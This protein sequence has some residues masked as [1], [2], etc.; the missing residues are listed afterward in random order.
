MAI[1]I[2]A[3]ILQSGAV[4]TFL[5]NERETQILGG[6]QAHYMVGDNLAKG[7]R[8]HA[9][10]LGVLW[11]VR[12]ETDLHY[13]RADDTTGVFY[14][15]VFV[16]PDVALNDDTA[17][18]VRSVGKP[19][20]LVVEVTSNKTARKDIGPKRAAYA[21]LGVTEYVTF[22][23]RPRKHLELHGYRLASPGQYAEIQAAAEG[24]L[25]LA[26]VGLRVV[27]EPPSQPF[28]GPL[29][30]LITR[31]GVR[32]L[33][34]DEETEAREAAE[35]ER[36]AARWAQLSAERARGTAERARSAAEQAQSAAERVRTTA[37]QGLEA[38]RRAR[39]AAEAEVARLRA[40]LE[41]ADQDPRP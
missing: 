7:L 21:E 15:D 40:L 3:P 36:D 37:E 17:Y 18:H 22:D 10:R 41:R 20:M 29:L 23:P 28:R 13:P 27:A 19:P 16:A 30:R 31:E 33:H 35:A 26:T 11:L 8:T 39:E 24:G 2:R 12:S 25:W 1:E 34:I 6:T 14:P 9:G 4:T 32:L 5:P 38:E